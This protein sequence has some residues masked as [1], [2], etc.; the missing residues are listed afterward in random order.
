MLNDLIVIDDEDCPYDYP[1]VV[2]SRHF[3]GTN[4]A[5]DCLGIWS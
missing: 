1:E 3:Y 4:I 2:Y 5:C